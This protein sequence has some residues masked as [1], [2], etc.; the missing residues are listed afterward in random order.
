MN[1]EA[2]NRTQGLGQQSP[3]ISVVNAE[4]P[5]VSAKK[6]IRALTNQGNFDVLPRALRNKIHRD[7]GRSCDRLFQE[8][9]NLGQRSLK[10]SLLK[11]Y[12]HM[13]SAQKGSSFR[14]ISDLVVF[15]SLP[16]PNGVRRPGSA[17]LIHQS[18]EQTRIET[19]AQ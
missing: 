7:N 3:P 19:A 10:F 11:S 5:F 18:Q 6:L 9:H 2:D 1:R 4:M 17:L 12:R 16:V 13:P 14:C 8:F 15:E